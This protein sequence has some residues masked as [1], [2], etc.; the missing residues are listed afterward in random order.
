MISQHINRLEQR[1][2][3]L[4]DRVMIKEKR[5]WETQYDASE[6]DALAWALGVVAQ[7]VCSCHLGSVC[8]DACDTGC[9]H[10]G[11]SKDTT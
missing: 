8:N 5:G 6:R 4:N 11:C 1:H 2:G 3:Y 7:V 9:H 10:A